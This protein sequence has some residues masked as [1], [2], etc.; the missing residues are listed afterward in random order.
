MLTGAIA[1]SRSMQ[2]HSDGKNQGVEEK[3]RKIFTF[4]STKNKPDKLFDLVDKNS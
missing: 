4:P 3:K 2:A 1:A